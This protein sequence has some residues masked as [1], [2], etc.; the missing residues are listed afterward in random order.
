MMTKILFVLIV[1]FSF[2]AMS[3]EI[4]APENLLFFDETPK[5]EEY[6]KSKDCNPAE[7]NEFIQNL[8][9]VSGKISGFQ[10]SEILKTKHFHILVKNDFIQVQHLK[11]LLRENLTVPANHFLISSSV[12]NEKNFLTLT[13]V[14]KVQVFCEGCNFIS[15]EKIDLIVTRHDGSVQL[16]KVEAKFKKMVKALK[17]TGNYQAFSTLSDITFVEEFVDSIPHTDLFNEIDHLKF[18]KFNKQVA[19][20]SLIRFSDL[21]AIDLVKAGVNTEVTIENEMIKLKTYGISR[22][23]GSLGKL[24][25]IFHP[26]KNKKYLGKVVDFNKVTVEL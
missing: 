18:Y 2:K 20:G 1:L 17:V 13:S 10:L 6:I 26:Q 5:L 16:I 23:N 7:K 15:N 24:V 9:L 22:S 3:C 4:E 25:E 21:T 11:N 8:F 19:N 14:D 12:S